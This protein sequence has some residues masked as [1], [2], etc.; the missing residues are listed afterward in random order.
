M[1]HPIQEMPLRLGLQVYTINALEVGVL[2]CL[3]LSTQPT[4]PQLYAVWSSVC[5]L[6]KSPITLI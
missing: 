2:V 3:H 5:W 1:S 6:F 4:W